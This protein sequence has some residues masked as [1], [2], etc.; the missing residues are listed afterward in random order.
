MNQ[1]IVLL[2]IIVVVFLFFYLILGNT[3]SG[4]PPRVARF[5]VRENHVQEIKAMFPDLDEASIRYDLS[6]TGSIQVTTEKILRIGSLPNPPIQREQQNPSR[7]TDELSGS[8]TAL[9]KDSTNLL[10]RYNIDNKIES[11]VSTQ[12]PEN[13]WETDPQKRAETFNKR[14]Q[15]MVLEARSFEYKNQW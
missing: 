15:F 5:S 2:L 13:K 4:S 1:A 3:S 11:N 10:N 14:K 9:K 12:P 6:K 8:S 7:N